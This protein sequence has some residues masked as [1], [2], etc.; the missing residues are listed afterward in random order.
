MTNYVLSLYYKLK[1]ASDDYYR[2]DLAVVEHGRLMAELR[3]LGY[4]PLEYPW[5]NEE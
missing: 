3:S 1:E 5:E 4:N 2:S